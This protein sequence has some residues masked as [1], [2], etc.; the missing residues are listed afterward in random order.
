MKPGSNFFHGQWAIEKASR[1][2]QELFR[3]KALHIDLDKPRIVKNAWAAVP[4]KN[5]ENAAMKMG[6]TEDGN[7]AII[8]PRYKWRK[9]NSP[10]ISKVTFECKWTSCVGI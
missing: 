9:T 4:L 5:L 3:P 8:I 10:G 7:N 2:P 6:I 1:K